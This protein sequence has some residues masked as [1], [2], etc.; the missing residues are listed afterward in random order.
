MFITQPVKP[1]VLDRWADDAVTVPRVALDET[2]NMLTQESFVDRLE[3]VR[4][5]MLVIG[6]K[7]CR[8]DSWASPEAAAPPR[9]AIR[10]KT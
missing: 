10:S 6:V 9:A 4:I 2:L 1:E 5:P 3:S 7:M 8:R